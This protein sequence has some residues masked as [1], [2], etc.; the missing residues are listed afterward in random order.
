MLEGCKTA[1][2]RWGGVHKLIDNWLNTRQ[3]MIV[4]YCNL[5]ASKPLSTE[6]PLALSVQ[7]FCQSMMD[8]C[9]AGHFEI[10]EQLLKEARDYDD[11]EALQ[12]AREIV[13]KLDELTNQCVDFND[14]FDEN[15]SFDMLSKL[16]AELSQIGEVL[17]DRFE[18]EDQLIERLHNIHRELVE[19]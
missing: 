17:E 9:S 1:Q 12:L 18:L 4:L 6:Q 19:S 13:P 16:P 15:C 10:Y 3:E 14:T 11:E 8:Y 5:S 7:R 2:E